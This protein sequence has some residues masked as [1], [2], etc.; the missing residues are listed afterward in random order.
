MA[1]LRSTTNSWPS[2]EMSF[3]VSNSPSSAILCVR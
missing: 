1:A 2:A 3:T